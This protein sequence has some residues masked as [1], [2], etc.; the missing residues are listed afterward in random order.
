[1]LLPFQLIFANIAKLMRR[2]G[3]WKR[4]AI[5]LEQIN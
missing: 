4:G 1:M 3:L 2:S 5:A